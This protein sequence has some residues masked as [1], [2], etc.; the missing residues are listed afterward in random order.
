M[1]GK[2]IVTPAFLDAVLQ[3]ATS[4]GDLEQYTPSQLEVDFDKFWPDAAEYTTPKGQ[5]PVPRP[6]E[7]LKPDSSRSEIFSGLTFIFLD[8]VQYTNLANAVSG[9]GGKALKFPI[10]HGETTV[11]EYV[12]FVRSTA[13]KKRGGNN[14]NDRLPVI[15]IRLTGFPEGM[16][17]WASA[18]VNGVDRALNQRSMLQNEFL[19]VILTKDTSSLQKPPPEEIEVNSSIAVPARTCTF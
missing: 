5:E 19:D 14:G 15:T 9:G 13:G 3:A 1:S 2:H 16:E 12:D 6:P 8:D 18:F 10:I 17:E 7:L 11:E 4:S